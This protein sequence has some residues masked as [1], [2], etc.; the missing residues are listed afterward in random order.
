MRPNSELIGAI[1]LLCLL[2]AHSVRAA[3]T[4][5]EGQSDSGIYTSIPESQPVGE[6]KFE[7]AN[8]AISSLFRHNNHS[9]GDF[10]REQW[11]SSGYRTAIG[12]WRAVFE[13]GRA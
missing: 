13:S 11:R 7:G 8:K 1:Y 4:L 2:N 5:T 12:R 6:M 3:C 9:S 10:R